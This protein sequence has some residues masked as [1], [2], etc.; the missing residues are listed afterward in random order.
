MQF[1]NRESRHN[2]TFTV[3]AEN[4]LSAIRLSGRTTIFIHVIDVNDNPPQFV[5]AEY[6]VSVSELL[7]L[8]TTI[9]TVSS[10]DIDIVS[11]RFTR[12]ADKKDFLL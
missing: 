2:Y 7:P 11:L 8:G 1:Q 3:V 4:S 5:K 12:F 9:V 6:K 10:F